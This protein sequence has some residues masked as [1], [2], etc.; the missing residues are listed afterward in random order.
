MHT[1]NRANMDDPLSIL[2][3]R[4]ADESAISAL[5]WVFCRHVSGLAKF[6]AAFRESD[7]V[8]IT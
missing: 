7:I 8:G 5:Y 1:D 6:H 4:I 2:L 3:A